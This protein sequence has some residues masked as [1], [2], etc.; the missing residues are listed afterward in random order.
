MALLLSLYN[1]HYEVA[2]IKT[3]NYHHVIRSYCRVVFKLKIPQGAVKGDCKHGTHHVC[4]CMYLQSAMGDEVDESVKRCLTVFKNR[5]R[6]TAVQKLSLLA[7][8]YTVRTRYQRVQ[9]VSLLHLAAHNG[10]LDVADD[11]VTKL[12]CVA[13]CRDENGD[14]PLHYAARSGHT[15]LVQYLVIEHNGDPHCRNYVGWTPLHHA[16][17][18]GYLSVVECLVSS[19]GCDPSDTNDVGWTALHYA[20][21]SGHVSVAQYLVEQCRSCVSKQDNYGKTPLQV[22]HTRG[23]MRIVQYL[24]HQ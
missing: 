4:T 21:S 23:H 6:R 10:W 17:N 14:T 8:P 1:Y 7:D 19:H 20:A 3:Y 9:S 16:A 24:Q 13:D 12:F 18:S 2:T 15:Q 11:L 5:D 22:A